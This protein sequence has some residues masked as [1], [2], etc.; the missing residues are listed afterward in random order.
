MINNGYI[1]NDSISFT[2]KDT[3]VLKEMKKIDKYILFQSFPGNSVLKR[4]YIKGEIK[5]PPIEFL[6]TDRELYNKQNIAI[7]GRSAN[8]KSV[9]ND[10]EVIG[11]FDT[12]HSYKLNKEM[13]LIPENNKISLKNGDLFTFN[14]PN[15]KELKTFRG[16][17][18]SQNVKLI[19]RDSYGTYTLKSNRFLIG[20]LKVCLIFLGL[21]FVIFTFNWISLSKRLV[22]ILYFSGFSFRE[23]LFRFY[24]YI[25]LPFV[26]LSLFVLAVAYIF[27]EVVYQMWSSKWIFYSVC[28]SLG[29]TLIF[30]GIIVLLLSYFTFGKG[31]EKQ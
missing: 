16:Y 7:I 20:G 9:P 30:I 17:L 13:W 4:A 6:K 11:Y 8:K 21:L 27:S 15:L 25:V 26:V 23:I 5:L 28:F 1:N 29:A 10:F 22:K 31:G 24:Q 2:L 14:T 18:E 19:S 12:P 3:E